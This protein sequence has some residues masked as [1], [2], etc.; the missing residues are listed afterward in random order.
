MKNRLLKSIGAVFLAALFMG[1]VQAECREISLDGKA[2]YYISTNHRFREIYGGAGLYRLET[3]I[4]VWEQL[5]TWVNLGYMYASGD[6][7][8]NDHTHLHLVPLSF[9]VSYFF[10]KG[11]FVPYVGLG[12]LLA[13]SYIHNG[14]NYVTRHQNGWGGGFLAKTGFRAYFAKSLYFD[15]FGDYSLII[16][17]F[18]HGGKRTIHHRGDLSG[19]SIGAGVGYNF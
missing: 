15:F 5:H 2:S 17:D 1:A 11:C 13:Y 16:M 3:N 10:T 6:S 19:F 9:G 14:S 18:H 12:P 8:Q 7:S 4:Q